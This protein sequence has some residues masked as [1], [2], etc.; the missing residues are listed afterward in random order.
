MTTTLVIVALLAA[1]LGILVAA[2]TISLFFQRRL[3]QL[4]N[5]NATLLERLQGRESEKATQ[6][7]ELARQL[8]EINSLQESL[9]HLRE[10]LGRSE[11]TLEKERGEF[12]VRLELLKNTRAEMT[13]QFE[14]LANRILEDKSKKFTAS[15]QENIAQIL[16][17]LQ[18]RIEEFEKKVND[19]YD[20]ESKERFSLTKEIKSLQELNQRISEDA[21]NLTNALKGDNKLLGTWGEM[22]LEK[23]L[24]NSGLAKG[25]EYEIQVSKKAED[26][27]RSQ[28]DVVVHLPDAKDVIIDSKVSLKAYESYCSET[29]TERKAEFL[30]LHVQSIKAHIKSLDEKDYQNLLG[31]NTL[32]F[33]L[34]FMPVDGAFSLAAQA[35]TELLQYAHDHRIFVVERS[36]LMLTLRVIEGVWR[37]E[38]Q[39]RNAEEIALQAGRLYDKFVGFVVDLQDIDKRIKALQDSY[40][41]AQNKLQAGKGNLISRV[42][43]LKQLG[44]RTRKLHSDEILQAAELDADSEALEDD[45]EP[46]AE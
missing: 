4:G 16:T 23:I 1:G 38:R 18:K 41:S 8:A 19:T 27:S 25:S 45:S 11:T 44:A 7:S 34:M 36:T 28:P 35:D 39:N 2:V 12:A 37:L 40:D 30:K 31:V 17:P 26:G 15:N 20:R 21:V 32:D 14:N 5:E 33:V 9:A 29:D 3:A 22:V 42:E 13:Q 43:R 6:Q 10:Q 46:E 24:E